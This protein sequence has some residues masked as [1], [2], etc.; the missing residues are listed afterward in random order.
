MYAGLPRHGIEGLARIIM[1]RCET[2]IPLVVRQIRD[3]VFPTHTLCLAHH[4]ITLSCICHTDTNNVLW[5]KF[6]PMSTSY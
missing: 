6:K 1:I 2:R 3:S 4:I 5:I